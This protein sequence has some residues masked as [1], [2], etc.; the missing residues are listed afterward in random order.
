MKI[1]PEIRKQL[2]AAGMPENA[3]DAEA[4]KFANDNG[5]RIIDAKGKQEEDAQRA[6]SLLALGQK[7][8][9]FDEVSNALREGKTNEDIYQMLLERGQKAKAV[10]GAEI[11]LSA[12]EKKQY[13]F[14]R[15]IQASYT[16]NWDLA[17]FEREVSQA[18]ADHMKQEARG[19]FVP[20]DILA[21]EA[22]RTMQV[23]T[24]DGSTAGQVVETNLMVSSMIELIRK[25]LILHRLGAR[26]LT[27]LRGNIAIPKVTGG[28]VTYFVPES[29]DTT[30]SDPT[31]S[32]IS[33]S[34]KT[35]S[36]MTVFSRLLT[37][38]SSIGVEAFVRSDIAAAIAEGIEKAVF[39][40]TGSANQPLGLLRQTGL[41]EVTLGTNG[42]ALTYDD[43]VEMETLVADSD[44]YDDGTMKY[45]VNARTRGKL[46]TTLKFPYGSVPVFE[47][48][49][50]SGEGEINGYTA[51]MS[52]LL[53]KDGT[54]GTGTNL[55]TAL[56][57]RWSDLIIGMWGVLDMMADPYTKSASGD[58]RVIAF[59]SFD[60]NI[61]YN[62][63]FVK[64]TDIDNTATADDA[65]AGGS[66]AP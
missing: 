48:G 5:I 30:A 55:C 41:H 14:I 8:G 37:L 47:K 3:S 63:S 52:N 25:R 13:Y 58:I 44:I 23:G 22:T 27:G 15:A 7:Y 36:G 33:M 26:F 6:I 61:R 46:K 1:T 56:F 39:F 4:E 10:S 21:D 2:V 49:A 19:F 60:T 17:P 66:D 38:Q 18:C 24:T 29:G 16:K 34:P 9:M 50:R 20:M 40:G 62:K 64:C 51:L 31:F 53:P 45:L 11:G 28:A 12:K 57:G 32:Q 43:V 35:I 59:Q 65:A 54:K 42:G